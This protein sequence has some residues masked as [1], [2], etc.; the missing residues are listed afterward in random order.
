MHIC[1]YSKTEL[2]QQLYTT[3]LTVN[4]KYYF[5]NFLKLS[6]NIILRPCWSHSNSLLRSLIHCSFMR[7]VGNF[8][9]KTRAMLF[10]SDK[11]IQTWEDYKWLDVQFG[12][13]IK[14][15][16]ISNLL[17]LVKLRRNIGRINFLTYF[18][19]LCAKSRL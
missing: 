16:V 5:D 10:C 18:L 3:H 11:L 12:Y 9:K 6:Y 4:W 7:Y 17:Q 8:K 1:I 19:L 13:T 15:S 2:E 14:S